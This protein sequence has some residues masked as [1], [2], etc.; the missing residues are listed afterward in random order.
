MMFP[1]R[2]AICEIHRLQPKNESF[3]NMVISSKS[4]FS[5]F[6][7]DLFG[8]AMIRYE[9]FLKDYRF[10]SGRNDERAFQ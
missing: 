9:C 10:N 7:I 1:T 4:L 3:I 6:H 5:Y 8:R 2:L